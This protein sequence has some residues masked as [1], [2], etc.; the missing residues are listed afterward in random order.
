[1]ADV[2][3]QVVAAAGEGSRARGCGRR[4]GP[5]AGLLH[6]SWGWPATARARASRGGEVE[7]WADSWSHG[8]G[9]AAG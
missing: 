9:R 5:R 3:G 8:L 6:A 1:M 2:W 7:G 4:A